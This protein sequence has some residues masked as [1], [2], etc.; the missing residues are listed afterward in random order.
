MAADVSTTP[1][2]GEEDDAEAFEKSVLRA[3]GFDVR[4]WAPEDLPIDRWGAAYARL[5]EY[6]IAGAAGVTHH[7]HPESADALAD[8][9]AVWGLVYGA[10]TRVIARRLLRAYPPPP[11][12]FVEVG[13]GWGPFA[14]A[15]QGSIRG[16]HSYLI[17]LSGNRLARARSLFEAS[18][19][20][21][22]QLQVGDA[23]AVEVPE[24]SG[25][26]VPYA[27]GEMIAGSDRHG[28]LFR[29]EQLVRRWVD[30]LGAGGRL[31]LLEPGT[32]LSSRRVQDL[33]DRLAGS[34]VLL[35]PCAGATRC[36][37]LADPEDWC[38]F[39][40]R[41]PLGPLG[42]AIADRARR[43]WREVHV[44]WL[45]VAAPG[46]PARTHD[47][48]TE[49][50]A[51]VLEVRPVGR[52]KIRALLCGGDGLLSLVALRRSRDA[53][54]ALNTLT[55]GDLVGLRTETLTVRGD[56]LRVDSAASIH[57]LAQT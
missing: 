32:L 48:E 28:A 49:V 51:R 15:A 17:D 23:T 2:P 46:A 16:I 55:P 42:R 56:G 3:L 39:T 54:D 12:R 26:A 25:I 29:A 1:L 57:R 53:Y 20:P 45:V 33:R 5:S 7:S 44:S 37:R 31:Y 22:P 40:W 36:P 35:G 14:H 11:G 50:R 9:D 24:A 21:A 6:L 27:L 18:G 30:C 13:A 19:F 52:A 38:H 34:T 41:A 4:H 43:R 10:R 8:M 47:E